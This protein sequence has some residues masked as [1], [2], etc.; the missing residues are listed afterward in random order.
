M[1][2]EIQ[3]GDSRWVLKTVF[4]RQCYVPA[5][6][7]TPSTDLAFVGKVDPETGRMFFV[8]IS[9]RAKSWELPDVSKLPEMEVLAD[10]VTVGETEYRLRRPDPADPM[11]D[12]TYVAVTD[13]GSEAPPSQTWIIKADRVTGKYT[14]VNLE[15]RQKLQT[16]PCVKSTRKELENFFARYPIDDFSSL[17]EGL[18]TYSE[19]DLLTMLRGLYG[20]DP[21]IIAREILT[22][23]LLANDEKLDDVEATLRE[24]AGFEKELVNVLRRE[25]AKMPPTYRQRVAAIYREH[26]PAK[27]ATVNETLK[28][29]EGRE[30]QLIAA[31]LK[32]YAG[33]AIE[34]SSD[35]GSSIAPSSTLEDY[36]NRAIAIYKAYRPDKIASVDE[37]L[38]KFKGQ[39]HLFIEALVKKYGPEPRPDDQQNGA[40]SEEGKGSPTAQEEA[41]SPVHEAN[42]QQPLESPEKQH[43][44]ASPENGAASESLV[45]QKDAIPQSEEPT[46]GHTGEHT[47]DEDN[48]GSN[49]SPMTPRSHEREQ[50]R[51]RVA[52][53]YAVYCPEKMSGL[54]AVMEMY[55][56]QEQLLIDSLV[57]KYGPEPA[58]G[59]EEEEEDR[60]GRKRG[61]SQIL[62]NYRYRVNRLY[63]LYAPDKKN[64]VEQALAMY[65]GREDQLI[66]ALVKKYGPEPGEEEE[67]EAT[68][69]F[70]KLPYEDRVRR[71]YLVYNPEKLAS[72]P[73]VL[74]AY[75]GQEERMII[76]LARKYGEEP[77]EDI[78]QAA[79]RKFE[80]REEEP[81]QAEA[82]H[83]QESGT[84]D[85]PNQEQEHSPQEATVTAR[86]EGDAPVEG[87]A[88]GAVPSD[89]S[90]E[91]PV[92][93][94]VSA[95]KVVGSD[96]VEPHHDESSPEQRPAVDD[97]SLH[98]APTAEGASDAVVEPEGK[99]RSVGLSEVE[100]H[101][102]EL[103][104]SDGS[105]IAEH[106]QQYHQLADGEPQSAAPEHEAQSSH[107]AVEGQV[108]VDV[109][110][111]Q[112]E[113]AG[114][115][116]DIE[117]LRAFFQ[118][119][120][121]RR[122]P[123]CLSKTDEQLQ[124]LLDYYKENP[125]ELFAQLIQKYGEATE[126]AEA[127]FA[128]LANQAQAAQVEV[129]NAP[130]HQA[131]PATEPAGTEEP[132]VES[133]R[134][135]EQALHH[136]AAVNEVREESGQPLQGSSDEAEHRGL[137]ETAA[138]AQPEPVAVP[139]PAPEPEPHQQPP[140]E[141][142][143]DHSHSAG[144]VAE[145]SQHPVVDT[146]EAVPS[147]APERERSR[148]PSHAPHPS[149]EPVPVKNESHDSAVT[150]S[151][152]TTSSPA[153]ER[154]ASVGP[155]ATTPHSDATDVKNK[156]PTKDASPPAD[157][158]TTSASTTTTDPSSSPQ[159]S[160][161]V[162]PP[163]DSASEAPIQVIPAVHGENSLLGLLAKAEQKLQDA[164]D[165][166]ELINKR[167][168]EFRAKNDH[169]AQQVEETQ[170]QCEMELRGMRVYVD[171][172]EA[173]S[174]KIVAECDLE[175]KRLKNQEELAVTTL[176]R[177]VEE[178]KMIAQQQKL[179]H[180]EKS[181]SLQE[182]IND[183]SLQ[184]HRKD[185]EIGVAT[186][187]LARRDE[188]IHRLK[189]EIE[190]L[191]L[192]LQRPKSRSQG[193]QTDPEPEEENEPAGLVL[194]AAASP[195]RSTSVKSD[196]PL[197]SAKEAQL[198][199]SEIR[200][201][202]N[203]CLQLE[204]E[205][206]ILKAKLQQEQNKECS[207]CDTA[208]RVIIALRTRTGKLAAKVQEL[209]LK[210]LSIPDIPLAT[211][212][213]QIAILHLQR[214]TEEL[215]RQLGEAQ[216]KSKSYRSEIADLRGLLSIHMASPRRK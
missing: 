151:N 69:A 149:E 207:E 192:R 132:T 98:P 22:T 14:F 146:P 49:H 91:Q 1:E 144:Q 155:A 87:T 203:K 113:A 182:S 179:Q 140:P 59:D 60:P 115:D 175:R 71:F 147:S 53:I 18:R 137:V 32:K 25:Y 131:P 193:S 154:S 44:T 104:S 15:T 29:V 189:A 94:S 141:H 93:P 202:E 158:S 167:C 124:S 170:K 50:Y 4:D 200:N 35:G 197:I 121:H 27:L 162:P 206:A 33:E 212:P 96:P 173:E 34:R 52:R 216:A 143:N 67:D 153:K 3:A 176:L 133:A 186:E 126:A 26:N 72:I 92:E 148:A 210:L 160:K 188:E 138:P 68:A 111:T 105:Q 47:A 89:H 8:N 122:H 45:E 10:V 23:T 194:P 201:W 6:T 40:P 211:E 90:A 191:K 38:R 75:A 62:E 172:V 28:S 174:Q 128:R 83:V 51:R 213:N 190:E 46:E 156:T 209:E 86:V 178:Q 70:K 120:G 82:A 136:N 116:A 208:A 139:A 65:A 185:S 108:A 11:A 77:S 130:S 64:T 196:R 205:I 31:L 81:P 159:R 101:Q 61:Y 150:N 109:A 100:S 48:A 63:D 195:T 214:E 57:Q 199:A 125:E 184:L 30:V 66:A 117:R 85:E 17:E 55:Q 107:S 119:H 187:L 180:L 73:T 181:T 161:W 21:Q 169:L 166:M 123:H 41:P 2:P 74:K 118:F 171:Q 103:H 39:E 54:N 102:Q 110:E 168:D 37:G 112:H 177:E 165:S 78:Y 88:A 127:E 129:D 58:E 95:E 56:G 7:E 9:T 135:E 97:Q 84:T 164:Y 42:E 152:P 16:L 36:R 99:E 198:A 76:D 5:D 106:P 43:E 204:E 80:G 157:G 12:S 145:A 114:P 183:L 142:E 215:R 20:P 13:D 163:S 24:Y 134:T 19:A 79:L